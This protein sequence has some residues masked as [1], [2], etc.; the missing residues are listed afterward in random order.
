[1]EALATSQPEHR[2]DD[3]EIVLNAHPPTPTHVLYHAERFIHGMFGKTEKHQPI[4]TT[5]N[6]APVLKQQ[7][8]KDLTIIGQVGTC[9]QS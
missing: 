8:H 2:R 9:S 1:M 7:T 6:W 3:D 4:F 5:G